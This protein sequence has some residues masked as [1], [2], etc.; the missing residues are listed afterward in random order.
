MAKQ[1]IKK[2]TT[3]TPEEFIADIEKRLSGIDSSRSVEN[4][5]K[6]IFVGDGI[7]RA[8]GLSRAGFGEEVEFEN[9]ARGLILN[10]DEDT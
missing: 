5:G 4:V 7:V 10:L 3:F 1:T 9:K 2:E 6:V 8:T